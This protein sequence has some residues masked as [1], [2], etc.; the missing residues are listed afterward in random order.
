MGVLVAV[1]PHAAARARGNGGQG[2]P[3]RKKLVLERAFQAYTTG[4]F[5]VHGGRMVTSE[6]ALGLGL[7]L[8]FAPCTHSLVDITSEAE[9][10]TET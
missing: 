7:V 2:E 3:G 4:A 5:T 1:R 6:T 9:S 10:A 8:S